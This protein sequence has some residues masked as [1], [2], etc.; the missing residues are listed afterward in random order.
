LS[1]PRSACAHP[2][3]MPW[4]GRGSADRAGPAQLAA[5]RRLLCERPQQ[6]GRRRR[7]GLRALRYTRP[8]R[9]ATPATPPCLMSALRTRNNHATQHTAG[10]STCAWRHHSRRHTP[11][12]V[13]SA[14]GNE[15]FARGHDARRGACGDDDL[16]HVYQQ[17]LP[18]CVVA[19][20]R[21]QPQRG[22][23]CARTAVLADRQLQRVRAAL[24]QRAQRGH[25]ALWRALRLHPRCQLS[26]HVAQLAPVAL[27]TH[28]DAKCG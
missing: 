4:W 22:C 13:A 24:A 10:P 5:D 19:A 1:A 17:C 20:A 9:R 23:D 8:A 16:L 18:R 26:G 15:S 12:E 7:V 27:R 6:H 11:V 3:A 28:A 14:G 21:A 2:P 25:H